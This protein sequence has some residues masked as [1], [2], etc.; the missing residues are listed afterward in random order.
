MEDAYTI[1]NVVGYDRSL[2]E[3]PTLY[4]L[5]KDPSDPNYPGGWVWRT[6]TEARSYIASVEL[7]FEAA[8]YRIELPDSWDVDVEPHVGDDGVHHLINCARIIEKVP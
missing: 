3:E 7:P 1:G 4:K 6:P 2:A 5:G 8:V